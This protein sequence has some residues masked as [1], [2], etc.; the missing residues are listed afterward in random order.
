MGREP[1]QGA[2]GSRA[3]WAESLRRVRKAAG[4]QGREPS[5]GSAGLKKKAFTLLLAEEKTAVVFASKKT[6][7]FRR[8]FF[9]LSLP[10]LSCYGTLP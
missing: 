6:P 3:A 7:F 10:P 9:L 4:Q 8:L 5:Q 1:S 2:E